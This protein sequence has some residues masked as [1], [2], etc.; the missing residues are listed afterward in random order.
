MPDK[1]RGS[2]PRN[3]LP[4]WERAN[5]P[6]ANPERAETSIPAGVVYLHLAEVANLGSIM[7][8][9]TGVKEG[10][11]VEASHVNRT[12]FVAEDH[13]DVVLA[14]CRAMGKRF[15][16]ESEHAESVLFLAQRLFDQTQEL[17]Q[18]DAHVMS[19]RI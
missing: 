14:S 1:A 16:Y 9:E 12:S 8:P 18:L 10:L 2:S 4:A 11:L 6:R 13:V 7:V 15:D 3:G 19:E 5:V 17:H